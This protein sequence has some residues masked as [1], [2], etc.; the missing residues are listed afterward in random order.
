MG[1]PIATKFGML[2]QF[3]PFGHSDNL[4]RPCSLFVHADFWTDSLERVGCC[5]SVVFL[6]LTKFLRNMNHLFM[7]LL[8]S[9]Y[10]TNSTVVIGLSSLSSYISWEV[11][12]IGPS[13]RT[14]YLVYALDVLCTFS[15]TFAL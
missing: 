5:T 1:G 7:T 6:F 11:S 15:N 3:D 10:L 2:T 4:Q 13:S 9:D 8:P 14:S 12:K